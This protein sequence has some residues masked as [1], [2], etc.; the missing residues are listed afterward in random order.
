M[1]KVKIP[2]PYQSWLFFVLGTSWCS[3]TTFFV[4]KTWF[5]VEGD[6]GL[7]KHAWQFP[8]LQIHGAAAFLMMI[9]VGFL[10]GSHIPYCWKMKKKRKS[11]IALIAMPA[12]LI[13]TAYLLYYIAEDSSRELIG[14]AHL[15]VGFVLPIVLTAHV[16]TKIRQKKTSRIQIE[17]QLEKI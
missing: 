6:Y 3:G 2:K 1:V 15:G 14:Y 13:I 12:F 9:S 11:G 5:I 4:L 17:D 7:V 10:L 16:L 8:A